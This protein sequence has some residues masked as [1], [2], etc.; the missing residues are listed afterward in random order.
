MTK[1]LEVIISNERLR[2]VLVLLA[3]DAKEIHVYDI[4]EE[5]VI[6]SSQRAAEIVAYASKNIKKEEPPQV[7]GREGLINYLKAHNSATKAELSKESTRLGFSC[8]ALP[9]AAKAQLAIGILNYDETYGYS[10]KE[11]FK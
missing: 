8:Q 5:F 2:Q 1:K 3:D 9:K 4:P 6:G 11:E 7:S 10:I